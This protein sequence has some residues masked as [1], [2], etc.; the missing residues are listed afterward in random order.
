MKRLRSIKHVKHLHDVPQLK[1]LPV[2]RFASITL[3]QW[4]STLLLHMLRSSTGNTTVS[5]HIWLV[6]S[7]V[8]WIQDPWRN[9]SCDTCSGHLAAYDTSLCSYY[10][11]ALWGTFESMATCKSCGENTLPILPRAEQASEFLRPETEEQR[12]ICFCK[13]V[14][15]KG[16]GW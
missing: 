15:S 3:P 8:L 4:A 7:N 9:L 10:I 16:K 14:V 6:Q 2:P 12:I 5:Q 11:K 1:L 13:P